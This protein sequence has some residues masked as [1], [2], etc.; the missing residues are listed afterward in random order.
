[1]LK[2]HIKRILFVFLG[3]IIYA[4]TQETTSLA[5]NIH[6]DA[7]WLT[8]FVHG[9]YGS[10]LT[11][12]S[13][14]KV[15]DDKCIQTNYHKVQQW[16][17]NNK[18]KTFFR[19]SFLPCCGLHLIDMEKKNNNPQLTALSYALVKSYHD[20]FSMI[21]PQQS[22]NTFYYT[23][24]WN[25]LLSQKARMRDGL[26]FYQ[27]LSHEIAEHKKQGRRPKVRIICHSHGGNVALNL[28]SVYAI[29]NNEHFQQSATQKTICMVA[30]EIS[31][32]KT[33]SSLD[34]NLCIDELILLATPIQEETEELTT[35]K[36][37]KKVFSVYS[38]NDII[39]VA[40]FISTQGPCS[41]HTL[42]TKLR[43]NKITEIQYSVCHQ[44][45]PTQEQWLNQLRPIKPQNKR[46]ALRTLIRAI[47]AGNDAP[48]TLPAL[49]QA[50][51]TITNL[52]NMSTKEHLDQQALK[53][54]IQSIQ[55]NMQHSPHDPSHGDFIKPSHYNVKQKHVKTLPYMIWTPL[56]CTLFQQLNHANNTTNSGLHATF[57]YHDK[58]LSI[59]AQ[60]A[61][62]V[63]KIDL[64]ETQLLDLNNKF[65]AY[66]T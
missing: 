15:L 49:E 14:N 10:F 24:G 52:A 65:A 33:L 31:Q 17:R 35:S 18:N 4:N 60:N 26:A 48:D 21:N 22:G 12:L 41:K 53:Q 30:Q 29:L 47:S 9:N 56:I 7:T 57:S 58:G 54:A 2:K 63:K 28:A 23:F 40:D 11:T 64:T 3:T 55:Q 44:Q 6:E 34:A 45:K 13:F 8:V 25:G 19:N 50:L 43:T 1:M 32:N 20:V 42:D 62:S 39:Q 16:L 59:T 27:A 66:M 61:T 5:H 51:T 36:L 38:R 37:F 46:Q